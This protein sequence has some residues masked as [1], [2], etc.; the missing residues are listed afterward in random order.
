MSPQ[1]SRG[2]ET[3]RGDAMPQTTYLRRHL[4]PARRRCP[5][6]SQ[7]GSGRA[8]RGDSRIQRGRPTPAHRHF[9]SATSRTRKADAT[10]DHASPEESEESSTPQSLLTTEG[11]RYAPLPSTS[12]RPDSEG[13][14]PGSSEHVYCAQFVPPIF[15][16]HRR[17]PPTKSRFRRSDGM[18]HWRPSMTFTRAVSPA[19]RPTRSFHPL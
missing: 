1:T 12:I 2:Q 4:P 19:Y 11:S 9:G 14:T 6:S 13:P 16:W 18:C 10:P 15:T 3:P 5:T 7:H 17:R 8:L